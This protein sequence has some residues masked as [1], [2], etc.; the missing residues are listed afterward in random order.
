M[1]FAHFSAANIYYKPFGELLEGPPFALQITTGSVI[2]IHYGKYD[3][4]LE[5]SED[6]LMFDNDK[7]TE[8]IRVIEDA[9]TSEN[10]R[11]GGVTQDV[12]GARNVKN[13]RN[14]GNIGDKE[15]GKGNKGGEQKD[16]EVNN[17]EKSD[18]E[19]QEANKVSYD[20]VGDRV[21]V[22]KISEDVQ[23]YNNGMVNGTRNQDNWRAIVEDIENSDDIVVD[24][25]DGVFVDVLAYLFGLLSPRSKLPPSVTLPAL[26]DIMVTNSNFYS[27]FC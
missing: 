19:D 10:T 26:V 13:A 18:G 23:L 25:I 5:G 11:D 1:T 7:I 17:N 9:K 22:G 4:L 21:D 3:K 2:V 24:P 27:F 8:D 16:V 12:G 14:T 15:P 6:Q 20:G